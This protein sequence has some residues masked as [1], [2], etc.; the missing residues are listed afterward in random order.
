M[1]DNTK[2]FLTNQ[3]VWIG[4]YFGIALAVTLLLD[5]PIS[6]LVV[7]AIILPLSLYRRKR[8]FKRFGSGQGSFFHPGS[9]FSSKGIDYYCT[10]VAEQN[11]AKLPV[12]IV[13]QK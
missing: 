2:Q 6:L 5:F 7:L 8:Y 11:I 13:A 10:S 3:L 4:I 12:R 9:M 1:N